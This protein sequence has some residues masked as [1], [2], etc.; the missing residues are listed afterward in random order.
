MTPDPPLPAAPFHRMATL[1]PA[2][3]G[4]LRPPLT[5]LAAF[6]AHLV[7]RRQ[8]RLRRAPPGVSGRAPTGPTEGILRAL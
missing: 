5:L 6:I 3:A 8:G 2:W 4:R 7:Q 1:R